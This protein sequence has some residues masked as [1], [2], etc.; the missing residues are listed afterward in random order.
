MTND[1]AGKV[2]KIM[3]TADGWCSHCQDNL[4]GLFKKAFPDHAATADG[5]LSRKSEIQAALNKAYF[6]WEE[7]FEGEEPS[8]LDTP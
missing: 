4:L 1:E 2:V 7:T 3:L 5:L 8:V 6:E